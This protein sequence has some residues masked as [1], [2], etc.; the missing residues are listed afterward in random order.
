MRRANDVAPAGEWPAARAVATATLTLDQRHRRRIALRCDDG[1]DVMLDLP[2]ATVL[3]DG[4]GLRLDDG[5]WVGV[6][7]APE[8]L[9]EFRC[10]T[11]EALARLA[12]HLGNRHLPMQIVDGAIRI[13]FDHV[14]VAMARGLGAS[15]GRCRAGFDPEGGAYDQH[16]HRGHDD[17]G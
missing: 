1:E 5:G 13:R 4:D 7:A 6:R 17:D 15:V 3:R 9:A 2:Q 14:V 8:E 10:A 12:W 11:P 16:S